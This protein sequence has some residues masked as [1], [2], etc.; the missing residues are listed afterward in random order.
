VKLANGKSLAA[1]AVLV[2]LGRTPY[3]DGLNLEAAGLT[4]GEKGEIAVDDA[5]RTDVKHIYAI[6]DVTRQI[7][8]AHYASAQGLVAAAHAAGER[9]AM[10]ESVVPSA[11][12]TVPEIASVGLTE[13]Q[14]KET[15]R[16]VRAVKFP[17]MALGR[18]Q[19]SGE[20]EGFVK[21]V[22]DADT[23][24]ILGVAMIGPEVTELIA[25]AVMAMRL[26]ATVA[27]LAETIHAHPTFPEALM[28]ASELWL[29][30]AIHI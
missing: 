28:E 3:T 14:A 10:H 23:E 2:T 5:C 22:A 11:I 6:G 27:E 25:E 17:F 8:L 30:K 15:G 16:N 1:D 19:A 21:I 7:M 24:E 20:P 29:G 13:A 26:E 18:A 12:F 9:V 4:L